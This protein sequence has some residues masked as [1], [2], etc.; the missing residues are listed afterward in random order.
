MAFVYILIGIMKKNLLRWT[1]KTNNLASRWN[2]KKR[3]KVSELL[4]ACNKY[5]PTEIHRAIRPLNELSNWKGSEFRTVLLYV[6][7]VVFQKILPEDEYA[8][9]LVLFCACRIIYSSAYNHFIT[10]AKDLFD[11]YIK[12]C[13][14]LYGSHTIGSNMHNLTHLIADMEE[15]N[16]TNINYLSTYKFE[17]CLNLLGRRLKGYNKPLEQISKRI[18]EISSSN[19]YFS[20]DCFNNDSHDEKEPLL[21]FPI[22]EQK[23]EKITLKGQ[24]VFSCRRLGDQWFAT[25]S[26][27][28]VRFA[29]ATH[30]DDGVFR[31]WG[32]TLLQRGSFFTEPVNSMSL[33]IFQSDGKVDK[34]LV[35]F[36]VNAITAKIMCI[37]FE[38]E[39][40]TKFV[41]MPLLHTLDEFAN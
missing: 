19:D 31:L 28:I 10:I 11:V 15:N 21:Q 16:V 20:I 3:G 29:H 37:E 9:F 22:G 6:G 2:K 30:D 34:N 32:Y 23:F 12:G 35:N 40:G 1:G 7:I 39:I 14:L 13:I 4:H 38:A 36:N 41:F 8:N 33:S 17:N 27:A 18:L 24:I 25:N 5:R 26:G